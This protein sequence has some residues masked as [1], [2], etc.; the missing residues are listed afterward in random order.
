MECDG[1]Y[2][3]VFSSKNLWVQEEREEKDGERERERERAK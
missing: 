2:Y 3:T 1:M